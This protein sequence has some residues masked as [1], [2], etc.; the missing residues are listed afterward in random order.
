MKRTTFS[1]NDEQINWIKKK[2]KSDNVSDS[3][4]VRRLIIK[5]MNSYQEFSKEKEL[6]QIKD[7]SLKSL[8]MSYGL[9]AL[10]VW[11]VPS[12]AKANKNNDR[13]LKFFSELRPREVY[14][15][16][17]KFGEELIKGKS[18]LEAFRDV[19]IELDLDTMKIAN[20]TK[21]EWQIR[22]TKYLNE[23][24]DQNKA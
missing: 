17:Q 11:L 9:T 18:F 15:I 14:P 5:E 12:M 22:I 8:E 24:Q 10:I 6:E 16:V 23:T 21:D 2:A 20:V 7:A 13:L 1:L 4:F 3:E 19:P